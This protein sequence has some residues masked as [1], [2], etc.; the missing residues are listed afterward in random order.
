MAARAFLAVLLTIGFYLLAIGLAI[1]LLAVPYLEWTDLHRLNLRIT[2]FCLAGAA[3]ILFS[4]L[5]TVEHFRAPGE[6]A[7]PQSHPRLFA[8]LGA[9][10]TAVGEPL[11]EE[12]YL[13]Q[14]LNAAVRQRGGIMGLGGRR[15]ML[16]GIPLMRILRISE[17]RAVLAHE[18]GHYRGHTQLAPWIY[19]T[20]EAIART[21]SHLSGHSA[22]LMWPFQQYAQTFLMITQ[23]ISR[24]QELEAD[25]LAARV[26]GARA[27]I[28]GL[29]GVHGAAIA[30]KYYGRE[31][32][33]IYH[34]GLTPQPEPDDNFMRFMRLPRIAD[35]I[36]QG[37]A[38]ELTNPKLD[39]YDSHP[40][41]AARIAALEKLPPGNDTSHEPL[42]AL[43]LDPSALANPGVLEATPLAG[44][45]PWEDAGAAG[46]PF[47]WEDE[48]RRNY[49]L[50][51]GWT[52]GTLPD[53]APCLG[54]V[55]GRLGTRW[56]ADE[57]QA[58]SGRELLSAALGLALLRGGWAIDG[59]QSETAVVRKGD[60]VVDPAKEIE[61]LTDGSTDAA[62]WRAK[63]TTMGIASLRLDALRR[64]A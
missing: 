24:Q 63:S 19:K 31:N 28:A 7:D 21:L 40:P 64:A 16:L 52:V 60:A 11:P 59:A 42:A 61:Q 9:I 58:R 51:R 8:E 34:D 43:L 37:I 27:F 54:K 50:L 26:A 12:V 20:R 48:V 44:A 2:I 62:T 35:A 45:L 55:G 22:L 33:P 39:P 56:V 3:I 10:A 36:R 53:L 41:L 17:F 6:R 49:H 38:W 23:A 30:Y 1:A 14:D 57:S 47:R 29:R 25:A 13:V 46:E 32:T 5:P 4:I 18:F 15:V